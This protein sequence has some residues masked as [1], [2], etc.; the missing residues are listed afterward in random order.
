MG[1][2]SR[3]LSLACVLTLVGGAVANAQSDAN[4]PLKFGGMSYPPVARA[5]RVEGAVVVRAK[6]DVDG[7]VRDAS[8]VTGP[9]LLVDAALGSAKRWTFKPGSARVL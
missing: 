8:A 4:V 3:A 5:A 6:V 9:V 7:T 2:W 1:E